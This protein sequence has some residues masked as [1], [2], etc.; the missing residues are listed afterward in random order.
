MVDALSGRKCVVLAALL[1]SVSGVI[2]KGLALDA[3]TIAFYRSLFAGLMLLPLVPRGDRVFRP[4]MFPLALVFG[5]MIG[6]YISA[7]QATSAANAIFLQFTAT[8]WLVP[9][10][11]VCF[12]ER[13]DTG[14]SIGI[15]LATV[16]IAL[17][18]TAGYDPGRPSERWGILLGLTSGVCYA[19][20]VVGLRQL[21]SLNSTWLSAVNNLGGAVAV[22]VFTQFTGGLTEIPTGTELMILLV[23]GV[24]QMA[25]PYALFARG[26][27]TTPAAE[28]ALIALLE[29]VLNP[30]WVWLVHGE[31]PESATVVGG[32][33]LLSAVASRYLVPIFRASPRIRASTADPGRE[34]LPRDPESNDDDDAS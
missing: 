33:F 30:I 16:G 27:R 17:I 7:I 20:V 11:V 4:I 29:P 15:G 34:S 13:P 26:L 8:L 25:I 6:T 5:A 14:S 31:L 9:L 21:R 2:T 10:G 12:G 1:W 24:L 19:L 18:V 23:F 28:A 22:G 3:G 32:G